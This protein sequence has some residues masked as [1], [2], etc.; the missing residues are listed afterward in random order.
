MS[1]IRKTEL[2]TRIIDPIVYDSEKLL[3]QIKFNNG[4]LKK[5]ACVP[6]NVYD[7]LISANSKYIYYY[8]NIRNRYPECAWKIFKKLIFNYYSAK[9]MLSIYSFKY[10]YSIDEQF[11]SKLF[12][13]YWIFIFIINV[14]KKIY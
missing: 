12:I 13:N 3:L 5:F 2:E 10:F 7:G 11:I 9:P 8:E 1:I 4:N 6:K 14:F